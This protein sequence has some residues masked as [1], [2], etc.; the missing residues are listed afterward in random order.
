[1]TL[2][3]GRLFC[4]NLHD[5]HIETKQLDNKTKIP[6]KT[7]TTKLG[8]NIFPTNLKYKQL[9]TNQQPQDLYGVSNYKRKEQRGCWWIWKDEDPKIASKY[10]LEHMKS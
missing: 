2:V 5:L 7:L 9:G 8:N 1:M 3:V 4:F 6:R 10:S